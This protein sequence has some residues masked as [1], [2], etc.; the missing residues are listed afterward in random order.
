MTSSL[1]LNH[2]LLA[3]AVAALV[4]GLWQVSIVARNAGP[5]HGR[6]TPGY[7]RARTARRATV[8]SLALALVLFAA[9]FLV[10]TGGGSVE[11]LR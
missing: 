1:T 9:A 11:G 8:W 4:Y 7:A 3:L 5:K 6:G 10:E 2:A